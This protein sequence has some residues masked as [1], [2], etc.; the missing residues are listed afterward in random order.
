MPLLKEMHVT[1]LSSLSFF[2]VEEVR[3]LVRFRFWPTI[4]ESSTVRELQKRACYFAGMAHLEE[5]VG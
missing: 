4:S 1:E 5:S 3:E 2:G